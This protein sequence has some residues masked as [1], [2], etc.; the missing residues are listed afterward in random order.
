MDLFTTTQRPSKSVEAYYKIF[1]AQ[2]DTVNAHGGKAGFH[3]KLYERARARIMAK[4]GRDRLCMTS[5]ASDA[6]AFAE[7]T[8]IK[9]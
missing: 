1:C 2:R 4:K 6:N 8:A 9:K 5:A 3:E 7:K